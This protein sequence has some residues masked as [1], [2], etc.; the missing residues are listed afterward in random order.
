MNKL[1]NWLITDR[2]TQAA[3]LSGK[4]ADFEPSRDS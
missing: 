1:G 2:H 4:T 3:L